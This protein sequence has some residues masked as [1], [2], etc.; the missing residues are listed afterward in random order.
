MS[1]TSSTDIHDDRLGAVA[2]ASV[3]PAPMQIWLEVLGEGQ[4]A[5]WAIGLPD[6]KVVA[7]SQ[8][9]AI[10]ALRETLLTR[11]SNIK[12]LSLP[13]GEAENPWLPFYGVLKDDLLFNDWADR[14]WDGKQMIEDDDELSVEELLGIL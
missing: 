3:I 8:E 13:V 14:F 10:A 6:C 4:I 7:G 2:V 1:L 12:I 9:E 5:A 11:M